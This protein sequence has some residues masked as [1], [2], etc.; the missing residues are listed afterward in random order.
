[1]SDHNRGAFNELTL[2]ALRIVA[3]FL[4]MQHGAQKLFGWLDGNQVEALMSRAGTAGVL[5]FFG[6]ILMM[7]GLLTKPV[8]FLLSGQ[9]A[10]AYFVAHVPN[11][12][13]P[14]MNRGELA[15]F[16]SFTWLFFSVNGPGMFS[17]DGWLQR[18]RDGAPIS[19]G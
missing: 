6:G 8:A 18:R 17:V 12:F 10:V 3:G 11:G 19:E 4:F 5:E 2:N 7:L 1:M 16:Y 13:W 15:A 9:M 14:I